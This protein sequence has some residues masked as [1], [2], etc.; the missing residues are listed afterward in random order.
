M[1]IRDRPGF[2]PTQSQE[3]IINAT[4]RQLEAERSRQ[5][6]IEAIMRDPRLLGMGYSTAEISAVVQGPEAA[7]G[8]EQAQLIVKGA[9]EIDVGRQ[10]TETIDEQLRATSDTRIS[11]GSLMITWISTG[12]EGSSPDIVDSLARL[13]FPYL[14]DLQT[15]ASTRP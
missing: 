6:M 15:Q 14:A 9:E 1:C 7:T 5:A 8:A 11:M 4:I 10:L 3:A 13:L 2:D 12:M